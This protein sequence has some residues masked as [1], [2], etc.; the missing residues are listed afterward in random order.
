[1]HNKTI[2]ELSTALR[3]GDLS[4]VEL[5]GHMLQRIKTC[6]EPLN[7]FISVTAEQALEE[8]AA[9]DRRIAAGQAGALT[10]IPIAH[11]DIFCTLDVRT[12]CGS[13]M[14]ENFISPYD[15]TVVTRLKEAGVVMLGK[16]NMDEFA[17]GSSN[18]TSHFGPV[19]NP[20]DTETV[21]GG[22]SGGSAAAVAARL[23]AAATGTDTGGSIRQPAALTGITGLKP[24][25]G[26]CSRW[27]MIAFASSL[28]QAG[29]MTRSAEDAALMLAAMAGFD[30]RDSTSA[31]RPVDDYVGALGNDIRGLRIG[32]VREFMGEGL[33]AG[34]AAS[35]EAA[36]D[37]LKR[38]GAQIVEIS[39][40]NAGLSVPAYYVVAP[41]EC[42]SNLARFDGVRYGHR[43]ADP[44]GLEDLYKR[45]RSEGFG[46]EVKRRIMIGTYALSAGYYD[47]YYLKAQKV[48]QLI[49]DDFRNAFGQCDVIVGPTAP[50]TAFRLGEKA[51]DPVSMY[52]QD[53]YTIAVN[54]AGLPGMSIPAPASDGMPVGLQLIGNYFDEARL[55]NVAHQLQLVTDWHKQA[56]AGFE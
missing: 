32:V 21:P 34:V 13:R 22:S 47:A 2:A 41:A 55:L 17:M 27:G 40:P 33:D 23:C 51:D 49:A 46:A 53:I 43:C 45:S 7:S 18:E 10:G 8:A 26:R 4:S 11:K 38:L 6:G 28:D 9:A 30:E 12:S 25:Y 15:A 54:L 56:P 29:P 16:T 48:R 20:W 44:Q 42:S 3:D 1:M 35:V 50:G 5:T 24:T 31:Q 36:L 14:L 19:R 52:L 39:L 37:E